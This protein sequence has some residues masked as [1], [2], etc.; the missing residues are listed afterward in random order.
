MVGDD[1]AGAFV[2]DSCRKNGVDAESLRTDPQVTTSINVGLVTADGERTFVTN[3]NGSLWK[4]KAA[5]FDVSRFVEARILSLASI[6][7]E[8][9][10]DGKSLQ[11]IFQSARQAGMIICAD[12]IR[13]RFNETLADIAMALNYVDYFFPNYDE[14]VLLTGKTDPVEIADAFL[15]CGVKNII[16]K[17]G[18]K[19]CYIKNRELAEM[20]PAVSGVHAVDTTGAGDNF[21]A[22]FISGLLQSRPLMACGRLANATAAVSVQS[23]GAT[24]G[25]Q[26]VQQVKQL[27]PCYLQQN[28]A[29]K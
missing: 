15:A 6:F 24:T 8:P 3:R 12:M 2:R 29:G 14:A 16:V 25:V 17:L 5:D 18:K 20:V 21:A 7:N 27:Y 4:L 26:S 13:P 11:W 28:I 19:G 9:L 1:P 23:V 22:G 10:L